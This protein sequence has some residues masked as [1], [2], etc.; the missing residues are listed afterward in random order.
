MLISTLQHEIHEIEPCLR[1]PDFQ[2]ISIL[3]SKAASSLLLDAFTNKRLNLSGN[4]TVST[5]IGLLIGYAV[6][7]K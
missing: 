3:K 4:R 5:D 2:R 6:S 7:S 1:I